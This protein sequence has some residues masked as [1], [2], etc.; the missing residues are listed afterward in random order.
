MPK[1]ELAAKK[2]AL[3]TL[4]GILANSS[5]TLRECTVLRRC[6]DARIKQLREGPRQFTLT[7][8]IAEVRQL[9]E[10]LT[11]HPLYDEE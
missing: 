6:C 2:R 1:K 4:A 7:E 10:K 3:K 5:L 9:F 11:G 8:Q